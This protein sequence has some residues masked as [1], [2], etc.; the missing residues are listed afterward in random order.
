MKNIQRIQ[1]RADLPDL[2]AA[3]SYITHD[4]A[5]NPIR[6]TVSKRKRQVLEALRRGPIYCASPVRLSQAVAELRETIA[7][8]AITTDWFEI[9]KDGET[10][11]YGAYR[12]TWD[13]QEGKE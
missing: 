9:V 7:E 13:V 2:K 6:F 12:L 3:R 1:T 8:A 11:R 5:G 4:E 10:I